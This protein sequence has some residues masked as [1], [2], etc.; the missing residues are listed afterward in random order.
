MK[1][2]KRK[3]KIITVVVI[4]VIVFI[5]CMCCFALFAGIKHGCRSEQIRS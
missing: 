2:N 4:T 3:I 1:I 5:G